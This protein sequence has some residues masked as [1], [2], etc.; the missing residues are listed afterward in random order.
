VDPHPALMVGAILRLALT[1]ASHAE[2]ILVDARVIRDDGDN[3]VALH[4]DWV[5]PTSEESLRLLIEELPS[6]EAL[7][8]DPK[9]SSGIVLTSLISKVL[10]RHQL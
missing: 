10:R 8:A 5:E 2:Q 3:G 1:G 6:I 9:Q 4:F 7:T